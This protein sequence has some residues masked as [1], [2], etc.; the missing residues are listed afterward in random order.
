MKKYLD[1]RNVVILILLV[2]ALLEFVNPKGLIPNRTVYVPKIDSI[3][4][5]VHDT[6][7][8]DSL[9]EVEVPIEVEVPYE[10]KVPT[11]IAVDT[12]NILKMYYVKIP[13]K[14]VLTL[15]NNLGTVSITDTISQ[16]KVTNRKFVSNIKQ[17]IVRD[18]IY[19]KEPFKTQFFY[20]FDGGFNKD[21][22][23]SHLGLGMILKTKDDKLFHLGIGVANRLIDNTN[24]TFIPYLNG[25]VYWKIGKKK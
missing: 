7:P 22:V 15:P 12:N 16:N 19:Q 5:A 17:K 4:Y 6:I 11:Y 18:T 25:G 14:D 8:V 9:V 20:G 24:G 23:V 1:I 13:Y 10:V 2:I 3:P 21:N